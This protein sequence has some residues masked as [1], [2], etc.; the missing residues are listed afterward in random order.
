MCI[1]ESLTGPVGYSRGFL[2][3]DQPCAA[4]FWGLLI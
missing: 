4:I 2:W 3:S 1:A